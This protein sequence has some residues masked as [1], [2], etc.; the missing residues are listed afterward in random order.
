MSRCSRMGPRLTA[1]KKVSAPMIRMVPIRRTVNNGVVTGNVPNDG[2]TY[3]F[4]AKLPA[5]AIM[6]MII[7]NRPTSIVIAPA[8][9]YQRVLV[10]SPANADPLLPACDVK[11][12]R[13]SVKPCGPGF[14]MLEV[15][16]PAAAE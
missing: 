7:R 6:G 10:V 14:N 1:G 16:N 12:Y 2:G 13:I 11:A 3:F 9:L 4:S 8:A 5:I 15:P